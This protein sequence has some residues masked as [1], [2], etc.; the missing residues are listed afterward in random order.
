M[1]SI[2]KI[3]PYQTFQVRKSTKSSFSQ[4]LIIEGNYWHQT[5][6]QKTTLRKGSLM[7]MMSIGD[8]YPPSSDGKIAD[9]SDIFIN[10]KM[11]N[12][13]WNI[14]S[15]DIVKTKIPASVPIFCTKCSLL[16]I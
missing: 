4:Y 1:V 2:S 10:I 3:M 12:F 13:K 15:W 6:L 9:I 16:I 5:E 7:I 8:V 14:K 11:P